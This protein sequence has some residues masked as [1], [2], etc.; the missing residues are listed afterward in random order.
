M[1]PDD[2]EVLIDPDAEAARGETRP[3]QFRFVHVSVEQFVGDIKSVCPAALTFTVAELNVFLGSKELPRVLAERGLSLLITSVGE[4]WRVIAMP[5]DNIYERMVAAFD[6]QQTEAEA[7]ERLYRSL[8]LAIHALQY[9][10]SR[11]VVVDGE[12]YTDDDLYG[13]LGLVKK[14]HDLFW[15]SLSTARQRI[16][17]AEG[18]GAANLNTIEY[19]AA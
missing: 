8:Y 12:T 19:T 3:N 14:A 1:G 11:S 16:L 5:L 4:H 10:V 17:E 15:T 2:A 7:N 9:H 6:T 18:I 13:E